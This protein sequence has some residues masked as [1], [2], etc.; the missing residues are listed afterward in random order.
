MTIQKKRTRRT[1]TRFEVLENGL[2]TK[3]PT[4]PNT[5]Q[6]RSNHPLHPHHPRLQHLHPPLPQLDNQ[7]LKDISLTRVN[8]TSMGIM[9]IGHRSLNDRLLILRSLVRQDITVDMNPMVEVLLVG[10]KP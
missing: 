2:Q 8:N 4:T 5:T 10:V 9:I 1:R 6:T 3:Q 7:K